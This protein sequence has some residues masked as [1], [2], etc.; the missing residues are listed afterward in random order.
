LPD[1]PVAAH[2][3]RF[4]SEPP[5]TIHNWLFSEPATFERTQR[6]FSQMKKFC[7]LQVIVVT[8]SGGV[9]KWITD[10]FLVI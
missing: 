1:I 3:N 10:F 9:G 7:N 4:F 5:M 8:F 2:H 6:T